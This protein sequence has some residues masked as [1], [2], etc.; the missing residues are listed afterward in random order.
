MFLAPAGKVLVDADYSQIE[1]R[2]LAH[3]AGDKA[4]IDGFRS[5]E[6]IHTIT[7]AQ[8]FGVARSEVTPS[9][10]QRQGGELRYRVRHFPSLPVPG[11]RG[12]RGRGQGVYG[13]VL[14]PL[15]RGAG[16][17]GRGWWSRPGS[18]ALS[19]PCTAAAAGC[20]S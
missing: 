9:M 15:R 14:C 5:G 6:D 19:P 4:M 20:R 12:H 16:L 2:L 1:L 18:R 11:H 3:I 8:V 10:P 17:Y 7:A 13:Q